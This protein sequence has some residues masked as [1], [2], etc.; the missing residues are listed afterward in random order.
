MSDGLQNFKV[1]YVEITSL[2]FLTDFTG[3]EAIFLLSSIDFLQPVKAYVVENWIMIT[4]RFYKIIFI[5][6]AQLK[7]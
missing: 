3:K 4:T 1:I 2:T 6:K 5:I 7:W